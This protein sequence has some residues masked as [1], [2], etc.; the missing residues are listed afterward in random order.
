MSRKQ[1]DFKS[2]ISNSKES[3]IHKP[4]I[5]VSEDLR[6]GIR[7]GSYVQIEANG[8]RAYCQIRGTQGEKGR[9]EIN[10]WY[11]N[12]LGWPELPGEVVLKIKEADI[13]GKIRAWK[14]HPDDIVRIGIGL[15][16]IGIGLGLLSIVISTFPPSI[17]ALTVKIYW[18]GTM[19]ITVA[20]IFSLLTA[21]TLGVGISATFKKY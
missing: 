12:I 6:D 5:R 8:R 16:A 13:L 3:D 4:W 14:S 2:K 17:T 18:L 15:G 11:R 19:G 9:V 21:F 10:E 1:I 20:S 7:S